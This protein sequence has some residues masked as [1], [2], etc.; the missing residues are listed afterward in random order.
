MAQADSRN[1]KNKGQGDKTCTVH[2]TITQVQYQIA[3]HFTWLG[4]CNNESNGDD[5]NK[6]HGDDTAC[7]LLGAHHDRPRLIHGPFIDHEAALIG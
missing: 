7:P 4:E 2:C 5:C 1:T 6:S 3:L